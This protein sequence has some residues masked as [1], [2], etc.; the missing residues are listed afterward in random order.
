[1]RFD[2]AQRV[3]HVDRGDVAL[4]LPHFRWRLV[5]QRHVR[6]RVLPRRRGDLHHE[7]A[8]AEHG[9][10]GCNVAKRLGFTSTSQ[11]RLARKHAG[12]VR[13]VSVAGAG[14]RARPHRRP[15]RHMVRIA[16]HGIG[17]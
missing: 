10:H 9:G 8:D 7:P 3:E 2:Q 6:G 12:A 14:G 5:V 16:G 17:A 15:A 1:M 4:D 11:P 13:G